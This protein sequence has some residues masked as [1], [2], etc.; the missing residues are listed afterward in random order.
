MTN[1]I[2]KITELPLDGR[3]G[4][5]EFMKDKNKN[6]PSAVP[7]Q[8]NHDPKQ[9]RSVEGLVVGEEYLVHSA[10]HVSRI[11]V[12]SELKDGEV[13]VEVFVSGGENVEARKP[14]ADMGIIPYSSGMWNPSN[15]AVP[16][17]EEE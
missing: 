1:G 5:F 13:K 7:E 9:V 15:Y 14:L 11:K 17:E 8:P 12:L 2:K 16:L 3:F 6:E 4:E 10:D